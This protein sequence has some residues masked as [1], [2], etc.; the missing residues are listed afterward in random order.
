[1]AECGV[2]GC[3]VS[4]SMDESGMSAA[5]AHLSDSSGMSAAADHSPESSDLSATPIVRH[6]EL[7]RVE[8]VHMSTL[9]QH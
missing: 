3:G 8:T 1:M 6:I 5:A 2:S 4:S 7:L 9:I